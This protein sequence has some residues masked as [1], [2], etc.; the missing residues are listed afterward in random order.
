MKGDGN[1]GNTTYLIIWIIIGSVA[2]GI[3]LVTSSFLFV[4][5]TVGC[6]AAIIAWVFGYSLM[7]QIIVFI[8]VSAVFMAVGYPFIKTTIK[9]TVKKTPTMEEGYI[10]RKFVIDKDVL[11]KAEIKFD[12]IYWTVKNEGTPVKKGDKVKVTGIEGNKI[13]IKKI[14]EV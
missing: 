10:G 11:D 9:K 1:T 4:W 8:L 2:L 3:D 12:G 13:V 6:T 14:E 5:F 7:V